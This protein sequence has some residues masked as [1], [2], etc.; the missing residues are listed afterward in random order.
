MERSRCSCRK[1]W[2]KNDGW[3]AAGRIIFFEMS[4]VEMEVEVEVEVEVG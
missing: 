4:E 1:S 2:I 3:L